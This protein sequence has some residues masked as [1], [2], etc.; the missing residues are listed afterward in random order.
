[1]LAFGDDS[2]IVM[3]L[4]WYDSDLVIRSKSVR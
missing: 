3:R 4:L 2:G 1:M